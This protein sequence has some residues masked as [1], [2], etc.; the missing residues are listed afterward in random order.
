MKYSSSYD[1]FFQSFKN[2]KSIRSSQA[3]K[4]QA[5]GWIL[6]IGLSLQRPI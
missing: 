4:T 1:F 5:V 2:V 3:I 6:A